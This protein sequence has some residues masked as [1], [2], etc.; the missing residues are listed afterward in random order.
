MDDLEVAVDG[1][2]SELAETL[3]MIRQALFNSNGM[4]SC[5]LKPV[6]RLLIDSL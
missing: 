1:L 3:S 2:R 4:F 5:L 6:C